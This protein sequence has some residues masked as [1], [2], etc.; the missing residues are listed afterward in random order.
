MD[1]HPDLPAALHE[2][3]LDPLR[4]ALGDA[5]AWVVGGWIRDV[6]LGRGAGSDVDIAVEGE[7]EPVLERLEAAHDVEVHDHHLR[8]GTATVRIGELHADLARTRT[9]T[10]SRPG[11]LPDVEPASMEED[12]AR[13]D[14]TV[15]AMALRVTDP[16]DLLDPHGGAGDLEDRLLRV[17]HGASFTDDPT[18]AIRGA[19]YAARLGLEPEERT[20]E[21]LQQA[22]LGAVSAD[23]RDAELAR[24]AR[25]DEA[26]RGFTLL[27]EWRVVSIPAERLELI[28]EVSR[29]ASSP[30]F[31]ADR[32]DR[33]AAILLAAAGGARLDA[34]RA[35]ARTEPDRPSEAVRMAAAHSGP[36]LLLAAAD[37]CEW[38]VDYAREWRG[39]GLEIGGDDLVAAGI[40]EGP[41][42]GIG[43]RGALER[44][45]DGG[46]TGGREAELELAVAL[47][48]EAV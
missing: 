13:R 29:L 45:L 15:N 42:V 23:R 2:L 28:E 10:Y 5:D 3:P 41:A 34:A 31:D 30:P 1:R 19:R 48:R 26:P 11:A 27:D 25:E 35:L 40:P 33:V 46:L 17:L 22:D 9:E 39:V 7:L 24:L 16:H 36:E 44:K 47:A 32:R 8:F 18:R 6:L 14:F 21:L 37:G 4:E 38:L 43:L 20:R 12:L